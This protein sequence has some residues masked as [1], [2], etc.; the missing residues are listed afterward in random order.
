MTKTN[1]IIAGDTVLVPVN[2]LKSYDKNPRKGDVKAIA[3]S[4]RVNKQYRPIVVQKSTNKILAG[5]HTWQAA[6]SL[7]WKEL[8][9]T[10]VDVDDD[11]AKRIVLADNKTNDLADYDGLI[12]SELLKDLG[13]VSGTGYSQSDMQAI[14]GATTMDAEQVV[15]ASN[16]AGE[17]VLAQD[18]TMLA[19]QE[20]V[21]TA[22][23]D[24]KE[25][26]KLDFFDDANV[27]EDYNDIENKPSDLPSVFTLKDDIHFPSSNLWQIPELLENMLAKELPQ[28]LHTWAG[29]ATRDMKW[30]GYWLYNWGV[31]STSGMKDLS[32]VVASFYVWSQYSEPWW[33]APSRHIS[34]LIN[35]KVK[36][37]LTPNFYDGADSHAV[38]LYNLY[39]SRW[40]ARYLQ[41]AGITIIPSVDIDMNY[42]E[43]LFNIY[44][45]TLPKELP[46]VSMQVQNLA[47]KNGTSSTA[48]EDA[49]ERERWVELH[50]KFLEE[51][52]VG[53][54]LMY[55]HP[56]RWEEV[57]SWFGKTA[58]MH[59]IETRIHLLSK[60][61]RTSSGWVSNQ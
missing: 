15:W 2:Q 14:L 22:I 59:F 18:D 61:V 16:S 45:A 24:S 36:Y 42:S 47:N 32:K 60:R 13:D 4:L 58:K 23:A 25:E 56:N 9:V 35:A 27:E 12:L 52:K 39:R 21:S 44:L 51:A 1:Q 54:V 17:E 29:S 40:V 11:A 50:K 34:K 8:A 37:S 55:A 41:E 31:D 3:E 28:P 10:F 53:T 20:V 46:L 49:S 38:R 26:D 19:Q 48:K 6:K 5:N 43:E 30:D 33:K 7:G 57:E